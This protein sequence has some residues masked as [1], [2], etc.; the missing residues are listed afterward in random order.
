MRITSV[1]RTRTGA[2]SATKRALAQVMTAGFLLL[3]TAVSPAVADST[4]SAGPSEDGDAP[5]QAGTSFR[6]ATEFEQGRTATASASTGDYLYWSFP[7]DAYQRPTVRAA[8]RLPEGPSP[9]PP[10]RSTCTTG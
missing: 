5:T 7:A 2:K 1:S 4:P 6:T 9:P 10:G 3:G 8:V